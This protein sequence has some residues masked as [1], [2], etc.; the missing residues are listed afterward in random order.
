LHSQCLFLFAYSSRPDDDRDLIHDGAIDLNPPYQRGKCSSL[1]L[2]GVAL[3]L[4]RCCLAHNQAS[5][6]DRLNLSEFLYTTCGLCCKKGRRRG[7]RSDMR[8]WETGD[9]R[10]LLSWN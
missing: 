2:F 6:I 10:E 8:R 7:R 4:F 3:I 5:Q 9:P 1:T